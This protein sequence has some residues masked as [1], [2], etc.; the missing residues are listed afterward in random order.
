MTRPSAVFLTQLAHDLRSPLSVIGGGL[1]ELAQQAGSTADRDQILELSHRAVGR[2]LALSD[3]LFLAGRLETPFDVA[4]GTVDLVKLTLDVLAPFAKAQLR[5]RIQLV[6]A[7]PAQARVRG[8]PSLLVPLL[9]E[10]LTNAN[11]FV[12]R[13]LRVEIL[14]S[15]SAI[16]LNVDDDGPGVKEDERARLFEP[17]AERR[18]RTGL[19]MGL[20]IAQRLAQIHDGTLTV[21]PLAAGTRQQLTL[22]VHA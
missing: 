15:E 8:E 14:Q 21:E 3:R 2:L 7:F 1:T 11:R 12:R 16:V 9:L 22:P 13:E 17:F 10:L 6:K 18:S 19:G 4:L 20:W 5:Q